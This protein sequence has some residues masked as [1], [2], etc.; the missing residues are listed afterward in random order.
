MSTLITLTT[1]IT[2]PAERCFLLSLSIDLHKVTMK[3]S[4]EKAIGGVT[5]GLIGPGK[6]VTWEAK[7]FG[8]KWKMQTEVNKYQYPFY[9]V[10]EMKWGPFKKMH[11]QHIFKENGIDTIMTDVFEFEAPAGIFGRVAEWLFL[12]KKLRK[13][14]E[15]R[16]RI[17]KKT[18]QTDEWKKY[19][20]ES[21]MPT[22]KGG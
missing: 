16:N 22:V 18:A 12:A 21:S 10:S 2:A 11:H 5:S 19:L 8:L 9:F 6:T 15:E 20:T 3:D 13:S 14:L 1:H 7:H 4:N 17:I